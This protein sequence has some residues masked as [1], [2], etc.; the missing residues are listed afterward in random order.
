M[1][2]G[3]CSVKGSPGVTSAALALAAVWPRPVVLL[4][5]D[6][7]GGDLAYR[8]RAAHGGPVLAQKGLLQLAAT[9]RGGLAEQDVLG[10][11]AQALASGVRLIQGVTSSAQTRG[12]AGIWS[13]I[14]QA[15]A[16]SSDDVVVDLGRLDRSSPTM[17][18]ARE[19]DY[20]I[21]VAS[22]T[23]ESAMHLV[24][25]LKDVLGDLNTSNPVQVAPLLVGPDGQSTRDCAGLDEVL[26]RAGLPTAPTRAL[27]YDPKAL[28]R[29]EQGEPAS[30]RVGRTLLIRAARSVVAAL[31]VTA[32]EE[33][34]A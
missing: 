14:A 16:T 34:S 20:L 28:Y 1:L 2:I 15:C 29:I 21:P 22:M 8:C 7:V 27:P 4:E 32:V 5:A 11:Q 31:D 18:V 23:L 17:A 10:A 6:P 3:L 25:G 9:V 24:E 33:V 12:F 19:C 30:G 26:H 13:T